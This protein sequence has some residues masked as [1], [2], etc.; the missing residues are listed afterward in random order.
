MGPAEHW[1]CSLSSPTFDTD[2]L[3]YFHYSGSCLIPV[4]QQTFMESLKELKNIY[5]GKDW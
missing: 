4:T 3:S 2:C 1:S 5:V